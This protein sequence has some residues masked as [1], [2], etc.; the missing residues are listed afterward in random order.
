MNDTIKGKYRIVR[1]IARSNDIVYEAL[2]TSLQRRLAIKELNIAPGMTGQAKRE[3]VERFGR[4]ARAAGKLSHS[5]IVHI[6]DHWE[7]NGRYFIAMEYLEGQNLRDVMQTRGP[8]PLKEAIDIACQT[9][10][11]LAH[12]HHHKVI[13]RD[14]KPDNIHILPGSVVKLTDFGIARLSEEPALTSNGQVFGTPSYMSPEQIEGKSIDHRSDLFSV[15][16]LL[17]EMLAGRKPFIGDSVI[18]ITYAI[19]NAPVPALHGVPAGIE[20]VI[21]RAL[22]KRPEQR[23]ISAEQMRQD[24]R[25]AEQT[26]AVFLPS[27]NSGV[28]LRRTNM[29]TGNNGMPASNPYGGGMPM[30]QGGPGGQNTGYTGQNNN[31][32]AQNS[33]YAG[34]NSGYNN[35]QG[36]ASS[37]YPSPNYNNNSGYNTGYQNTNNGSIQAA[38]NQG[39]TNGGPPD[40]NGLPWAWNSAGAGQQPAPTGQ[41]GLTKAQRRAAQAYNQVMNSPLTALQA[42]HAAQYMQNAQQA[43]AQMANGQAVNGAQP[44]PVRPREPLIVLSPAVRSYLMTALVAIVIGCLLAFGINAFNNRYEAYK[45]TVSTAQV[46]SLMTQGN[47]AYQNQDYATAAQLFEQSLAGRPTQTDRANLNLELGYTYV[48][49]ARQAKAKSNLKESLEDYH[50]AVSYAPDY[51]VAHEELSVLLESMQNVQ[52]AQSEREAAQSSST[53]TQPP[54]TLPAPSATSGSTPSVTPAVD[55]NQLLRSR[56]EQAQK[57]LK[58]GDDLLKHNDTDGA[59]RKWRDARDAAPGLPEHDQAQ[60]RIDKYD[61]PNGG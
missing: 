17:Y 41:S 60:Q 61:V 10:D 18:S 46:Q 15:G 47:S 57:L 11:A 5:N 13:H 2:D 45:Q 39:M 42:Q 24:L 37:N 55:P 6:Y 36:G 12:A 3:R 20:Q 52:G 38:G 44:F 53:T 16:V 25:N 58:D 23:Q 59:L 43:N 33:G 27:Q 8:M 1:E 28:F 50:K 56:S 26:P 4:E 14:I 34:Q 19:M 21:Q 22:S 9:L 54:S 31:Y 48:Q 7:E 32:P 51:K 30:M 29:G 40:P 49:L 35:S